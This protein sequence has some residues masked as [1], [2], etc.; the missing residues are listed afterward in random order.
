[1]FTPKA[2]DTEISQLAHDVTNL[3]RLFEIE[4]GELMAN[5]VMGKLGFRF[6]DVLK[7][8]I[9]LRRVEMLRK[10]ILHGLISPELQLKVKENTAFKQRLRVWIQTGDH[11]YQV[12]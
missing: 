9:G 1:M 2:S 12:M 8:P 6:S 4:P 3:A 7:K 11:V 5:E 10:F